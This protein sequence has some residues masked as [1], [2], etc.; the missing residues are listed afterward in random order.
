MRIAAL[1]VVVACSGGAGTPEAPKAKVGDLGIDI[2][3]LSAQLPP[4]ID[5]IG[6]GDPL[7]VFS[8]YVMVAQH[9]QILWRGAYGMADRGKQRVPTADTSFRI[10]SVTKQFTATAI[11]RLEQD[12]KLKV[13][14]TVGQHL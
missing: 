1:L 13:T 14:D 8:G 4:F 9:D 2:P 6:A 3:N 7:R 11:L 10:G 5:S 12:G